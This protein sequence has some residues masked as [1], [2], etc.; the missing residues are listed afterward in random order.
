MVLS[1]ILKVKLNS[2]Y[3]EPVCAAYCAGLSTC[4]V[5]NVGD[6]VTHI[7]CIE[8]GM[9]NPNTRFVLELAFARV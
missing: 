7:S 4:C 1:W 2:F 3:Q 5:V 6:E 8:E 9:S